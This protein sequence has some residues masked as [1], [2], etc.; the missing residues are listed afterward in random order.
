MVVDSRRLRS[1]L[2][3]LELQYRQC[4]PCDRYGVRR[5]LCLWRHR[6]YVFGA[7]R[8]PSTYAGRPRR[9][10]RQRLPILDFIRE[11]TK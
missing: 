4:L 6:A 9:R 2:D 10:P 11:K 5:R 7:A 8:F 1:I 3:L